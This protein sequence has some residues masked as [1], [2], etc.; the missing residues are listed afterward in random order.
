MEICEFANLCFGSL[1][2]QGNIFRKAKKRFACFGDCHDGFAVSQWQIKQNGFGVC[3]IA[4]SLWLSQW[5]IMPSLRASE[6]SVV[7]SLSKSII[8]QIRR[9]IATL[10][11]LV[12]NDEGSKFSQWQIK[13][14]GFAVCWI[15][16][17]LWLSQWQSGFSVGK[18]A[19][20]T[21]F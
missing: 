7:I 18:D 9:E 16:S 13:Q 14:N 11:S 5:Q 6:T 2:F 1:K 15:A 3:W 19:H 17:S 8:L 20:P 21:L 12:R 4:S 10:A